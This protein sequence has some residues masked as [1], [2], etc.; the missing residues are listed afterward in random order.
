MTDPTHTP[1]FH[2]LA[3]LPSQFSSLTWLDYT[4]LIVILVG[5]LIGNRKGF[6]A[7]LGHL[8][9]LV[10]SVTITHQFA[11]PIAQSFPFESPIARMLM[12]ALTFASMAIVSMFC[13]G[14]VFKVIGKVLQFKFS[15]FVDRLTGAILGSLY[16]VLLLSFISN[17]ALIFPGEWLQK[18]YREQALVGKFLITLSPKIHNGIIQFVPPEW[19]GLKAEL[20]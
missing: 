3:R 7:F 14:I 1:W 15:E 18:T 6:A 2:A 11:A 5:L 19:R 9:V 10:F 17:F 13:V 4:F 16:F 8:I 12:S 20:K